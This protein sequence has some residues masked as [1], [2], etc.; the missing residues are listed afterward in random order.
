VLAAR[1]DLQLISLQ[2]S[3]DAASTIRVEASRRDIRLESVSFLEIL[4]AR[5]RLSAII[6]MT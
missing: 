3:G 2:L 6:S 5:S 1:K 4:M